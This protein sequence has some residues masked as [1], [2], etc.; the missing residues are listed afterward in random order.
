MDCVEACPPH[1]RRPS[2]L[3]H[4]PPTSVVGDSNG[5]SGGVGSSGSSNVRRACAAVS[6]ARSTERIHSAF[7]TYAESPQ[8]HQPSTT[9]AT[10]TPATTAARA[11]PF[12]VEK[13]YQGCPDA[14]AAITVPPEQQQSQYLKR[15]SP[16]TCSGSASNLTLLIH[17]NTNT[18]VTSAATDSSGQSTPLSG[19]SSHQQQAQRARA[20]RVVDEANH[21]YSNPCSSLRPSLDSRSSSRARDKEDDEVATDDD[22]P[23]LQQQQQH[24]RHSDDLLQ[25]HRVRCSVPS[26]KRPR[27][28]LRDPSSPPLPPQQQQQQQQ[29]QEDVEDEEERTHPHRRCG[30]TM[31]IPDPSTFV[32]PSSSSR[33]RPTTTTATASTHKDVTDPRGHSNGR[34][35]HPM[36]QP[37]QCRGGSSSTNGDGNRAR[38]LDDVEYEDQEVW[39]AVHPPLHLR[40]HGGERDGDND[41]PQAVTAAMIIAPGGGA[42]VTSMC[43]ACLSAPDATPVVPPPKRFATGEGEAVAL[44]ELRYASSSTTAAAASAILEDDEDDEGE[45]ASPSRNVTTDESHETEAP[46]VARRATQQQQQQQQQQRDGRTRKARV[47][48]TTRGNC[49]NSSSSSSSSGGVLASRRHANDSI[50]ASIPYDPS[51]F[52]LPSQPPNLAAPATAAVAAAAPRTASEHASDGPRISTSQPSCATPPDAQQQQGPQAAG[53]MGSAALAPARPPIK[54]IDTRYAFLAL[55]FM[56]RMLCKL[57]KGEPIPSSDFHSHCIPPMTVIMYVQRLVRYCACSGEALLC[58]FLLL[59]KYVF[60][61]GHPVTIYNAHRLLI[62]SIVLG[63]KLRDDV[64]YSNVYYGRIGGISGREM[65]KLELLFLEKLEWET[66]V[67]VDEYVALLDLLAE[68]GIDAEPTNAQLEAFAAAHPD[69]AA[70]YVSDE[71]DSEIA[72]ASAKLQQ[73]GADS[74]AGSSMKDAA[75]SPTP[76]PAAEQQRLKGLRGAYRLH[77]WHTLVVPWLARLERC[78]FAKAEANAAAAA[79]ARKEEGLRWQQYHREDEKAAALRHQRQSSASTWLSPLSVQKR[80]T[81]SA[82]TAAAAAATAGAAWASEPPYQASWP[83]RDSSNVPHRSSSGAMVMGGGGT[84]ATATSSS[85]GNSGFDNVRCNNFVNFASNVNGGYFG[86]LSASAS[87]SAAAAAAPTA[88]NQ[89]NRPASSGQSKSHSGSATFDRSA[90]PSSS[91]QC[92]SQQKPLVSILVPSAY[93]HQGTDVARTSIQVRHHTAASASDHFDITNRV[94]A[95][96]A[97]VSTLADAGAELHQHTASTQQQQLPSVAG[98]TAQL[99]SPSSSTTTHGSGINVN[100]QPYYYVSSRMRKQQQQAAAVSP[101]SVDPSATRPGSDLSVAGTTSTMTQATAV[102]TDDAVAAAQRAPL[103][104]LEGDSGARSPGSSFTSPAC[105]NSLARFST[106]AKTSTDNVAGHPFQPSGCRSGIETVVSAMKMSGIYGGS[107]GGISTNSASGS[108]AYPHTFPTRP[109]ARSGADGGSGGEQATSAHVPRRSPHADHQA[110]VH[111]RSTFA[112]QHSLGKKRSKPDS[113]KD[114]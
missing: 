70:A 69:E 100:A 105:V 46:S 18:S 61:S 31:H 10:S 22:Q 42:A 41:D 68:L 55:S 1:H 107:G 43:S 73:Q 4:R 2:Q 16:S 50:T 79:A 28:P 99:T 45:R 88:V 106:C 21:L 59:L 95:P 36:N 82:T 87:A 5:I 76:L 32:D 47:A 66:Q 3:A 96:V 33:H 26:S 93:Y 14:G 49:V 60:H 75:A 84:H 72:E 62:T 81:S 9:T 7:P 97:A 19:V 56:M 48:G 65:N 114:Y 12:A 98:T 83:H 91:G 109:I 67:H 30:A 35:S 11:S 20:Q 23:P 77:Q 29:Q 58:S 27:Q 8:Q 110:P 17:S 111:R 24:R 63:I 54:L 80:A 85:G 6:A 44:D 39:R 74:A 52:P 113:Y 102:G 64:Y 86:T 89:G 40:R 90:S 34:N 53:A 78:V 37:H 108:S 15:L 13:H 104:T 92:L 25:R 57:H 71:E 38:K 51:R 101:A 94:A 112:S 103:S